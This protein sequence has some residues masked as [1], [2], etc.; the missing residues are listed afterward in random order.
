[1]L[2]SLKNNK[3]DFPLSELIFD[4]IKGEI[5]LKSIATVINLKIADYL[6]DGPKTVEQL[7]EETNTHPN[8]LYRL[9]RMLSGVGIFT[10]VKE[11]QDDREN[12]SIEFG[13]TPLA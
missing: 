7:A 3:K 8:S 2:L 6:E 11:I 13:L 10:V 9:L 4:S 5:I 12:K 1:M